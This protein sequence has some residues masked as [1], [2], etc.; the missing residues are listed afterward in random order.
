MRGRNPENSSDRTTGA[1]TEQRLEFNADGVS[2]T[3]TSVQKDNLLFIP[4]NT[5]AGYEQVNEGDSINFSVPNSATPRGRVGKGVA[6]T[7][8]TACNQGVIS[9]YGHKDKAPVHHEVSPTLKAQSHGHEPMVITNT[10][11]AGETFENN[12]AGTIRANASHNY[13]TVNRIRRLTETECERLQ[14]L[15]DGHTKYGMYPNKP[16]TKEERL[17]RR[18]CPCFFELHQILSGNVHRVEISATQRYKLCGNGVSIPPVSMIAK[19][20]KEKNY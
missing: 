11:M 2:N 13:Q 5:K 15:P 3:L 4:A 16:K 18:K 1:P 6:Q 9:H 19:A 8:D 17:F 20:L 12:H 10:N 14:G 7:L